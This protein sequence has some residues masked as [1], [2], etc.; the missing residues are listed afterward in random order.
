M[1]NSYNLSMICEFRFEDEATR[2]GFRNFLVG[3]F[4]K[5]NGIVGEENTDLSIISRQYYPSY[6][7]LVEMASRRE[8]VRV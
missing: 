1:E 3:E 2:D 5:W 6:G 8:V 7:N 4:K